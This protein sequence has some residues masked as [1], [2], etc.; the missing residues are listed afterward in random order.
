[1]ITGRSPGKAA[2]ALSAVLSL[3]EW[4]SRGKPV[5]SGTLECW[6]MASAALIP[7]HPTAP[8]VVQ[9]SPQQLRRTSRPNPDPTQGAPAQDA[10][11]RQAAP[12]HALWPPARLPACVCSSSDATCRA[13]QEDVRAL[14]LPSR[15][16][17]DLQ[18]HGSHLTPGITKRL[19]NRRDEPLSAQSPNQERRRRVPP[20]RPPGP[21]RVTCACPWGCRGSDV[22]RGRWRASGR[23]GLLWTPRAPGALRARPAPASARGGC[24]SPP[25]TGAGTRGPAPDARPGKAGLRA[26]SGGRGGRGPG[27]AHLPRRRSSSAGPRTPARTDPSS[28]GRRGPWTPA[29]TCRRPRPVG[30]RGRARIAEAPRPPVSR[31]RPRAPP[32]TALPARALPVP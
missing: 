14:G 19:G 24:G 7:A 20:R 9:V 4:P 13:L 26:P 12:P 21:S 10:R 30:G 8:S 6:E 18:T 1:M 22:L 11:G 17:G 25:P 2:R 16:A 29:R 27:R 15:G 28:G 5:C 23:P 31:G 32:V 3:E